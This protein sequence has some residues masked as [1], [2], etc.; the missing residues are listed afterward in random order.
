MEIHLFCAYLQ[1]MDP[2]IFMKL[3]M[4]T[5]SN[6]PH[7]I[8][9]FKIL[10]EK[11]SILLHRTFCVTVLFCSYFINSDVIILF[12]RIRFRTDQTKTAVSSFK[13]FYVE[14]EVRIALN[15]SIL[16]NLSNILLDIFLLQHAIEEGY[17]RIIHGVREYTYISSV[18]QSFVV[19]FNCFAQVKY[20]L[21]Q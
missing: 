11:L 12:Y 16:K 20:E 10:F 21:Q 14:I 1:H 4:Y 17:V 2:T 3:T 15:T 5:R 13:L 19:V 8:K 7:N 9:M 6:Y 18:S